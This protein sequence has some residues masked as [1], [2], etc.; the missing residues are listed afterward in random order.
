MVHAVK[1]HVGR[2]GIIIAG[3]EY[4]PSEPRVRRA[5]EEAPHLF[6]KQARVGTADVETA[7]RTRRST[8]R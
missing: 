8:K 4:D 7:V 6:K 5:L 1:D 2:F 3:Q